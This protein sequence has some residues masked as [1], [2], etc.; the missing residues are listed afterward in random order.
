MSQMMKMN[1]GIQNN[2]DMIDGKIDS[3]KFFDF[4]MKSDRTQIN[5]LHYVIRK[6]NYDAFLFLIENRLVNFLDRDVDLCTPRQT[7]LINSAF[8]RI[9]IKE[10]VE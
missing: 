7:S 2:I 9:L 10:E 5:V 1:G 6:A 4:R 3:K 8:Y